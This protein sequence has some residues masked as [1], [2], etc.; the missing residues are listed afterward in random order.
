MV[1]RVLNLDYPH[2]DLKMAADYPVEIQW[3]VNACKKEPE[4]A[5]WI[6]EHVKEG[7]VFWD[8]GANVGPYSLIAA[9]RGAKVYAFEPAAPSY[10]RLVQNIMLNQLDIVPL[11]VALS[12][13]NAIRSLGMRSM[14]PGAASHD[15]DKPAEFEQPVLCMEGDDFVWGYTTDVS[16]KHLKI[17]VDGAER[18]VLEGCEAIIRLASSLMVEV[19]YSGVGVADLLEE[20]G[21]K[22]EGTW[23][24]SG[25]MY[26]QLW[27]REQ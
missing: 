22:H 14:E 18:E 9:S 17:D 25:E 12:S 23:H 2:A 26:N 13:S 10:F 21:L 27:M 20:A 24:R 16:P 8:V 19:D 11:P 15:W 1:S 3:R 6:H 5:D 7:D 4:T